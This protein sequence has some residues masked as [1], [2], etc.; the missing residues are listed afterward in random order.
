M[1]INEVDYLFGGRI[2]CIRDTIICQ[3]LMR[4]DDLT[5]TSQVAKRPVSLMGENPSWAKGC[6][7]YMLF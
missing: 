5:V 7:R 3:R 2:W 4:P 6:F 1:H